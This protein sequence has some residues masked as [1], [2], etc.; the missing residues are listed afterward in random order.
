MYSRLTVIY[1]IS[2]MLIAINTVQYSYKYSKSK[3][4]ISRQFSPREKT[5][6][7]LFQNKKL[8]GLY[9]SYSSGNKRAIS[10]GY[11]DIHK[12]LTVYHLFTPSGLH[13]T[14]FLA[15]LFPF[16]FFLKRK[17]YKSYILT[18]ITL[19][20]IPLSFDKYYSLKRISIF[21][22][23]QVFLKVFKINLE[24][25]HIFIITFIIDYIFGGYQ[26]SPL[27]YSY[28]FLFLGVI[29]SSKNF[30]KLQIIAALFGGQIILSYFQSTEVF[31]IAPLLGNIITITFT[32]M[33]P[34][35]FISYW[36]IPYITFHVPIIEFLIKLLWW[37]I[38]ISDD[39]IRASGS[40][41]PNIFILI[42]I[43]ILSLKIKNSKKIAFIFLSYFLEFTPVFNIPYSRYKYT[44][45]TINDINSIKVN[46]VIYKLSPNNIKIKWT[47]GGF[48]IK[49]KKYSCSYRL[50]FNNSYS[51]KCRKLKSR[52]K[53]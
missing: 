28:S 51:Y 10:K 2:I 41:Y 18:N 17:S 40:F 14:S 7:K 42:T 36:I 6:K 43:I 4:F 48:I 44:R 29:L 19:C 27:S 16:L 25:F 53:S 1:L 46:S 11:K 30:K 34:V 32:L 50:E 22:L 45:A 5:V 20:A 3:H 9:I 49:L 26:K 21:R 33:F 37:L 31:Y 38:S 12:R 15:F 39:I 52:R 24:V 23:I 13:M 47:K 8:A 35:I